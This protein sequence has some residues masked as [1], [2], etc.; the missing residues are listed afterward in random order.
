MEAMAL[1]KPVISTR[2][3]D[4]SSLVEDGVTGLLVPSGSREGL[5]GA[6]IRLLRDKELRVQMG[7][8]GREKVAKEF[9]LDRSV[10][11]LE[12]LIDGN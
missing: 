9:S 11:V 4:V 12:R 5:C 7:G 3:G 8:K 1:G 10:K 2:V 6:I